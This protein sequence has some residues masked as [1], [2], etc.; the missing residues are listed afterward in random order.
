[1]FNACAVIPVYNH[2]HLVAPVVD[3]LKAQG[4]V[5]VLVNDGGDERARELLRQLQRESGCELVEQY[6][7]G[8]KGRA[9]L[10]GMQHAVSLGFTHALQIDADGQHDSRDVPR[11]L[12]LARENPNA[13]IT[14]IPQ[15]DES[16]PKHRFY[17]RYLTHVWVWI[18]TLSLQ[19]KDS[20]CGFRVYPVG[21]VLE[22]A[23]SVRVG[24]RMDFDTEILVRLFWRGHAVIS[25]PTK[26]IYP[27]HGVSNFR[28][29][30]D[31][32]AISWMHTRLVCGM[33]W[34]APVLIWRRM[35]RSR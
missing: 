10:T 26:V 9:V 2:A 29:W 33:L 19:I 8:G 27:E 30:R 15:Y 18:E 28:L 4:L 5:C 23:R 35:R 1:M 6:P 20:M 16:V 13:V 32:V 3:E 11:L 7:N 24:G 14:G 31:N 17:S 12:A 22:L 21:P 34:R 25:L